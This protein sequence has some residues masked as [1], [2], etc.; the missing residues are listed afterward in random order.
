MARTAEA[1]LA[2]A[3]CDAMRVVG[4]AASPTVDEEEGENAA[5]PITATSAMTRS[6]AYASGIRGLTHLRGSR[7]YLLTEESIRDAC[8]NGVDPAFS[9]RQERLVPLRV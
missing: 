2:D 6:P 7:V 8:S 9:A 4:A 5:N 1:T 3:V